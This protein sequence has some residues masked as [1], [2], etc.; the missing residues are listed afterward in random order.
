MSI[1]P[2]CKISWKDPKNTERTVYGYVMKVFRNGMIAVRT[3]TAFWSVPYAHVRSCAPP[4]LNN[5][6]NNRAN[7]K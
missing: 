3:G 7:R 6:R 4:K 1:V 5:R 2:G